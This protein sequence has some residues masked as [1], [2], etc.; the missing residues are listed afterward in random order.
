MIWRELLDEPVLDRTGVERADVQMNVRVAGRSSA[1]GRA[2]ALGR[3]GQHRAER[4]GFGGR[5]DHFVAV[6]HRDLIL[7][8]RHAPMSKA[9]TDSTAP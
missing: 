3:A 8:D 2:A 6:D 5:H 4:A 9:A 1:A 7:V